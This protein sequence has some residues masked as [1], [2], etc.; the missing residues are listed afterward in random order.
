MSARARRVL[1]VGGGVAGMATA[2]R[3]A[4][5]GHRVRLL[6]RRPFLGGRAYSFPET[7]WGVGVDNGQHALLGCYRETLAFL[8]RIDAADR[9]HWLGLRVELRE[10]GRRGVLDAGRTPAPFH[11]MRALGG[12]GLLSR[13]E[14]VRAAMGAVR[15]VAAWK[16]DPQRLAGETVTELLER[17]GQTE[18]IR[19]RLWDPIAIAALNVHPS[20]A[21]AALFA[22]V[23]ERAFF[24]R[25]R[26][27]AIVLPAAPLADVFGGP[28][29]AA[30]VRAGVD[31]V[32][33]STVQSV[34]LEESGRV[35]GVTTRAGASYDADAVVLALPPPAIARLDV[36]G[37][38]ASAVLGAWVDTLQA[39]VPIVSVHVATDA[40]AALPAMVGLLGTT[41]QWV[42]HTDRFRD[43]RRSRGSL[44]SC[45]IS[46]AG[47]LEGW[48]DAAVIDRVGTELSDRVPEMGVLRRD[49]FH[50]VRERQATMAATVEATAARP[51]VETPCPGLLLA[52][53]WVRTGL[54]ATLESAAA[55]AGL[56]AGALDR[57][58]PPARPDLRRGEAA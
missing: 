17:L 51:G 23:V 46:D 24:G 57:M 41:T 45:V 33:R 42:F 5:G 1:V 53:D 50:V 16:R 36:G 7:S 35:V 9:L 38:P 12:Y 43:G 39:S 3:L 15:L 34:R 40:P 32:A 21:S 8:E 37:R 2:L 6:E 13:A 58:E 49:R 52:G 56:A 47:A 10:A 54:P 29:A 14:R 27:A 30:L 20:R 48:D 31:V 22:V 26:D 19:R 44:L 25:T 18:A 28:G 55:S 11:L 4:D